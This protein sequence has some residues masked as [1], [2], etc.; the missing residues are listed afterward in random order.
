[1]KIPCSI[2]IARVFNMDEHQ[3][4]IYKN[5]VECKGIEEVNGFTEKEVK[6]TATGGRKIVISGSGLKISGFS[7]TTGE[8]VVCG[9]VTNVSYKEK[10]VKILKGFFK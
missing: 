7:K 9:S 8:L 4:L 10:T 2:I 1:M 6:V 5:G 3:I